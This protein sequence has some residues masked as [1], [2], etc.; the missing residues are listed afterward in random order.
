[1]VNYYKFFDLNENFTKLDLKN[2]YQK[3][4]NNL[5]SLNLSDNDKIFY[6]EQIYNLYKKAKNDYYFRN[7]LHTNYLPIFPSF[8]ILDNYFNNL[9]KVFDKTNSYSYSKQKTYQEK[10]NEDG[11]KTIYETIKTN[12]NGEEQ[13]TKNAYK[14]NLNGKIEQIPYPNLL[15]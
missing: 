1:M 8:S 6:A 2:A 3:K 5:E 10:I 15:N 4:L 9:E 14:K 11:S 7:N 12:K 13:I